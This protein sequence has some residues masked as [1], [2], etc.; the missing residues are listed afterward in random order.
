MIRD[1]LRY[2]RPS[3]AEEALALLQ[4]AGAEGVVI[5]GGTL[6]VPQMVRGERRARDVV[7]LR[8]LGIDK[9]TV[10]TDHVEIGAMVTYG[11]VLRAERLPGSSVL[12][13]QLADVVTGGCQILNLGT[14]G[15]SAA[16]ATPCSDVPAALVALGASMCAH[17]PDGPR[18]IPAGEFFRDAHQT[19]LGPGE[20]LTGMRIP[21]TQASTGYVKMKAASSGWPV[22]TASAVLD[23]S[24]AHVTVG[25][26]QAVPVRVD[27]SAFRIDGGWDGTALAAAVRDAI[28]DPWHDSQAPAHYR[29]HI[30]G[31]LA[32]RAVERAES[33]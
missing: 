2:H 19:A 27:V 3:T 12:L 16:H 29:K 1:D 18:E 25:A 32:R 30:A 4:E 14:L 24:A 28:E 26:A 8:G 20:L 31:V 13:Q 6:V 22:V 15:G 10:H 5:G 7:D 9:L 23:D 21:V 17:G 11:T 33:A